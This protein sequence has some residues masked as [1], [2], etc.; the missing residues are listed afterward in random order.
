MVVLQAISLLSL[1]GSAQSVD[2]ASYALPFVRIDSVI[3][4][5]M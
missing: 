3:D 5:C 1:V 2:L 4:A